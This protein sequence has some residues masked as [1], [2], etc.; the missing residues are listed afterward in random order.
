MLYVEAYDSSV[1]PA[2]AAFREWAADLKLAL[3]NN[4]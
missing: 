3:A 1:A 2:K 4:P